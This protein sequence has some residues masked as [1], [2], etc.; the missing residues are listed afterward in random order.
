MIMCALWIDRY[1]LKR[2][3]LRRMRDMRK[4]EMNNKQ[5]TMASW[6]PRR[7]RWG[8]NQSHRLVQ[9]ALRKFS[10][11]D[12]DEEEAERSGVV[13]MAIAPARRLQSVVSGQKNGKIHF[14]FSSHPSHI[15]IMPRAKTEENLFFCVCACSHLWQRSRG[16]LNILH[17]AEWNRLVSAY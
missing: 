11:T 9:R 17:S 13:A 2:S 15:L 8:V 5:Q 12:Q 7:A 10:F 3:H 4:G 6:L 1:P 14:S 16:A